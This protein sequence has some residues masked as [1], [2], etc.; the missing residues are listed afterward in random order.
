MRATD[1]LPPYVL[2]LVGLVGL[3]GQGGFWA[4]TGRLSPSLLAAAGGL[5]GVGQYVDALRWLRHSPDLPV[6]TK[7]D[8]ADADP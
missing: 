1:S 4:F 6:P 8:D 5:V 3:V 7:G 2:Q